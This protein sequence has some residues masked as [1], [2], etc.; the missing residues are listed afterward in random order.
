MSTVPAPVVL[1]RV[2]QETADTLDAAGVGFS[3]GDADV[4]GFPLVYINDA[5]EQ[6][7]GFSREEAI[8]RSCSF[9]QDGDA[10]E[11]A[12]QAI[13]ETLASRAPGQHVLRNVRRDG[14]HFWNELRLLAP[15]TLEGR[16]YVAAI[17]TDI[18][19]SHEEVAGL[20]RE[21]D[22]AASALAT[23]SRE[24]E[25]QE[26]ELRQLRALQS[27]LTP[28]AA[29]DVGF[30]DVATAFQPAEAGVAGDFFLVAP[31]PAGS[32]L[33]AVGDV[34]GH[35]L[36]AATRASFVRASLATFA[37]FTDDPERLL[38]L[39]NSSLIERAGIGTDFVTAIC[40]SFRPDGEVIV[41]S[42][43]HPLPLRLATGEALVGGPSGLPLGLDL[44]VGARASSAHLA[45]GEGLLLFTDGLPE[46][47]AVGPRQPRLGDEAVVEELRAVGEGS[48]G[49]VVGRLS[50]RVEHFVGEAR[51]DD[52]C[53]V[54]VRRTG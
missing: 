52:L 30:L 27:A 44:D 53:L 48:V 31:G 4:P 19:A 39:A 18:T 47:R 16:T 36:Q 26:T 7:T 20:R 54:A 3:V 2:L 21:R 35:G 25:R 14:S 42:A 1:P 51:A 32:A 17:Q 23:A 50:A 46:A 15:R 13:R 43:G 9:L 38:S 8:G 29:L 40:A 24:L 6:I 22:R 41:A 11:A 45:E 10:D 12:V 49:E 28:P 34:V 33:V 37:G 5:F